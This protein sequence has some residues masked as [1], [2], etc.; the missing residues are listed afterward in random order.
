MRDPSVS[1]KH[2]R[3]D[4]YGRGV[5]ASAWSTSG[6]RRQ[7]CAALCSAMPLPAVPASVTLA[8][9]DLPRRLSRG[10]Y[11]PPWYDTRG[12]SLG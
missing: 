10:I 6:G 1:S 5:K 7:R 4:G 12:S 11:M 9:L 3:G 2:S 8:D